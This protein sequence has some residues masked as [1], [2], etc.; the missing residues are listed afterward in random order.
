[1]SIAAS[2]TLLN[3]T[4]AALKAAIIAKGVPVADTD[5]FSTYPTK[6]R[7]ITSGG[8]SSNP[9]TSY[10]PT[11]VQHAM[12]TDV[13]SNPILASAPTTGNMLIACVAHWEGSYASPS[14]WIYLNGT[15]TATKDNIRLL[16]RFAVDGDTTTPFDSSVNGA[17][18]LF[19]V[20]G[21][22]RD[23]TTQR[24][25]ILKDI[26]TLVVSGTLDTTFE[27]LAVATSGLIV[28]MFSFYGGTTK[29]VLSGDN[30][31]EMNNAQYTNH[32]V[33]SFKDNFSEK[34][35]VTLTATTTDSG[36][37]TVFAGIVFPNLPNTLNGGSMEA[38]FTKP[39]IVDFAT[40]KE[41]TG[42]YI[43]NTENG[44]RIV[45][46]GTSSN[47]NV[48]SY[49]LKPI[50]RGPGGWQL[51]TRIRRFTPLEQWGM[52]GVIIRD[53]VSGKSSAIWLGND[54]GVGF[55][56]NY[57]SDD[58]TW[59]GVSGVAVFANLNFWL[60]ITDNGTTRTWAV[61]NTGDFWTD[62]YSEA[63][64]SYITPT[65][66]GVGINPNFGNTSYLH[67]KLVGMDVYSF[68]MEAL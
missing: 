54:N 57:F 17:V 56:K 66:A 27:S 2:L 29:P 41:P 11:V 32:S 15:P 21:L 12:S 43:S 55:N 64:D 6:I 26:T 3:S 8:G 24:N 42:G 68:K 23:I 59:N 18:A 14:G 35:S 47:T 31:Q 22:P 30:I 39:Q 4:K 37:G 67:G 48:L 7:N 60:R 28:G 44:I 63:S 58:D 51:T 50:T 62:I 13:N 20:A 10:T 61:S 36:T 5:A 45:G 38:A 46:I 52:M 49:A 33:I 16:Y 53:S 34:T 19:E 25:S 65:H 40:I 9:S 1:L